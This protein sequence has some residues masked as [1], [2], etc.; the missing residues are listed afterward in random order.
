VNAL[1]VVLVEVTVYWVLLLI[2]LFE[3]WLWGM[4]SVA[5]IE[6]R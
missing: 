4:L 2:G 1:D 5:A 3:Y 6:G